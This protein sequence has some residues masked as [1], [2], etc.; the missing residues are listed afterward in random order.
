MKPRST[1]V[2]N[3]RV[4]AD[5]SVDT[6]SVGAIVKDLIKP[7]M[8]DE[9]KVL[10]VFHWLRRIVYH[11]D[12]LKKYARNFNYLVNVSGHGSCVRQTRLAAVVLERLGYR[13]QNW[14]RNGHHLMQVRWGSK[15]HCLD[16]HMAFY[17]YNRNK[18]REIASVAELKADPSLALDA[19]RENR[20]CPGFLLCGDSP[21]TFAG[22]KGWKLY[23]EFPE[24]FEGKTV[25]TEPFGNI[26]LR[27]G[28][29]YSRSW[30]PG[31]FW[32]RRDWHKKDAGPYHGCSRRDRKDSVNW[33]IYEAHGWDTPGGGITYRHWGAGKLVY[34]PNLASDGWRDATI[35]NP[36]LKSGSFRAKRGLVPAGKGE[37]GI[38]TF[39]VN[40]PYVLTAGKLELTSGGK[41]FVMAEVSVD[42]GKTWKRIEVGKVFRSEIEGQLTGYLLRVTVPKGGAIT[43]LK[44][45][46]HFQLNAYSLPHLAPGRN[47]VSITA[48]EFGAA[49]SVTYKWAEGKDWSQ[50]RSAR[51]TFKAAGSFE[52]LIP[53]G[54][55]PR[56]K[57]LVLSVAP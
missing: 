18:P 39:S 1:F 45:T 3:P 40:C 21:K 24:G 51:R 20:A 43:A 4:T 42:R 57:T 26:A 50:L 55:H 33:P 6:S 36:S 54:K 14:T 17:V 38:A 46:S 23:G 41:N 29:T 44:L 15:W 2:V 47:L 12:G 37:V 32:Y 19:E 8:S 5:K 52:I 30:A 13:T 34:R 7:G 35:G 48:K 28:E 10:A 16:P 31:R 53:G 9:Q 22:P 25:L 11:G 56:M 27:R 49:L